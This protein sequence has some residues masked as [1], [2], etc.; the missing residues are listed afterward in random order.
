MTER[1]TL[2]LE[3]VDACLAL[4]SDEAALSIL[5]Q[6]ALAM[7]GGSV[8]DP[9]ELSTHPIARWLLRHILQGTRTS[10]EC[11]VALENI[12]RYPHDPD[13]QAFIARIRD[14]TTDYFLGKR[15]ELTEEAAP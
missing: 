1:R 7:A 4:T 3:H 13:V 15:N 9:P 2:T 12:R 10:Q 5:L 14:V 11:L 8:V 6:T